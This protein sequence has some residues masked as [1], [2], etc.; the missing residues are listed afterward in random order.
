MVAEF[1]NEEILSTRF[2]GGR[3]CFLA[4][5]GRVNL[6]ILDRPIGHVVA[7][8]LGAVVTVGNV[9]FGLTGL[10]AGAASDA[11]GGVDQP[12]PPVIGHLVVGDASGVPASIESQA[13]AAAGSRISN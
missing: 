5:V 6:G 8:D 7:L 3:R 10:H 2:G 12:A 4:A 11:L 13:M 9:V 1:R